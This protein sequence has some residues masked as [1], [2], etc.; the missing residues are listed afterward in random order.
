MDSANVPA[1]LRLLDRTSRTCE[2]IML[3][4]AFDEAYGKQVGEGRLEPAVH[5][6]RHERAFVLGARDGKLPYAGAAISWLR[7][8]GYQ[9]SIRNSG[10]AAVPLDCGVVNLSLILP[11][12]PGELDIQRHFVLMADLIRHSLATCTDRIETGEVSGAY[13]PGEY[14][15]SLDGKKFCGIAQRRQTRAVIIQAFV[16]VEGS[17]EERGR[18]VTQFYQHAAKDRAQSGFPR[19][20]CARMASLSELIGKMSA[21]SFIGLL[22][23][24]LRRRGQLIEGEFA[25]R[26]TLEQTQRMVNEYRARYPLPS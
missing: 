23:Q 12:R 15:L 4:F 17:G 1:R 3:P 25:A 22:K 9:V 11:T 5:L 13:C 24:Q 7:G 18:L 14:D 26:E 20:Q 2:A 10:G 19:V 6:W 16:L 8:Q 21:A